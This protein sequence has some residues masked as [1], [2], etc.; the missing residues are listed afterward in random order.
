MKAMKLTLGSI[1]LTT[2]YTLSANAGQGALLG[3]N[4]VEPNIFYQTTGDQGTTYD[5]GSSTLTITSTPVFLTF[6]AGGAE[7]FIIGGSLSLTA[8][9]DNTGAFIAGS[10]TV[11]GISTD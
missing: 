8:T 4:I 10:Y 9:I 3:I 1:L 5:A 7:E 6:E 2:F 11:S